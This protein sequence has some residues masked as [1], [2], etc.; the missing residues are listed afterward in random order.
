MRSAGISS[1][2]RPVA[3]LPLFMLHSLSQAL[4][5]RYCLAWTWLLSFAHVAAL[6][7][8]G[9]LPGFHQ[10][11]LTGRVAAV[12]PQPNG[13]LIVGG[14]FTNVSGQP[15]ADYVVRW[16]GHHW[17]P[18]GEGPGF[19]SEIKDLCALPAGGL[20]AAGVVADSS[21]NY[22]S[23]VTRWDGHRWQQLGSSWPQSYVT[24]LTIAS[25][26]NVLAGFLY[27]S[28]HPG[29]VLRWD[30]R[31][32][33]PLATTPAPDTARSGHRVSIW[34]LVVTAAGD[35]V[36][37]GSFPYETYEIRT[38]AHWT[39]TAWQPLGSA[40]VHRSA[41]ALELTPSGE[42]LA[43]GL[44]FDAHGNS[45]NYVARWDGRAWQELGPGLQGRVETLEVTPTGKVRAT[46]VTQNGGFDTRRT[47][48]EQWDGTTWQSTNQPAYQ[49][50]PPGLSSRRYWGSAP[51]PSWPDGSLPAGFAATTTYSGGGVTALA[52]ARNGDV[53]LAGDFFDADAIGSASY[54]QH[55]RIYRWNGRYRRCLGPGFTGR[56]TA[57]AVAPNG[58]VLAAG[59]FAL[60]SSPDSIRNLARW[61]GRRWLPV[62]PRLPTSPQA[63]AV[64]PN[65][66]VLAGGTFGLTRW[67]GHRWRAQALPHS[68]ASSGS[69]TDPAYVS[70]LAVA[71]NGDI[72]AGGR[73]A[74]PDDSHDISVMR[75]NGGR[76]QPV[77]GSVE[78]FI[79]SLVV[80]R[81][82][83]VVVGTGAASHVHDFSSN[84]GTVM[85][86][87]SASLT[88]WEYA[89][90]HFDGYVQ[91]VAIAANG[92]LLAGGSFY[93]VDGSPGH[94]IVRRHNGTWQP[95]GGSGLNG[96]V[97]A[98]V[99]APNGDII[100]GGEFT[101]TG[102][103]AQS[104]GRWGIYRDR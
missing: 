93:R 44:L 62:G 96:E 14:N 97:H 1:P 25:D 43:G 83:A 77:E 15:N 94:F 89:Y 28:G 2:N 103:G 61:D 33:Q 17:Q 27:G 65:G 13:N 92:D 8:A 12:L 90:P 101:A 79:H 98:L 38:V 6:A 86:S 87:D 51:D 47:I 26:G 85:R 16:D 70:A 10:P 57:L 54:E 4:A 95:L 67:D 5:R 30:G 76:W 9:W 18:L 52:I 49:A 22:H 72:V 50:A 59:P 58:D 66:D 36:A 7:Q 84:S 74:G 88:N 104:L 48:F 55:T 45:S 56:V 39:G 91:A 53:L 19:F 42:V 40:N 73:F 71:P 99:V 60:P 3:C 20:V 35:L 69:A 24:T 80:A 32:W 34:K 78:P 23:V 82:G 31:R 75:W 21:G 41:V 100:V 64:A 102:D 11:G 37:Y 68:P 81:N 63:I 46:T 29:E